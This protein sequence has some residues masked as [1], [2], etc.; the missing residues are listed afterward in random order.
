MGEGKGLKT[1]WWESGGF[2]GGGGGERERERER[3]G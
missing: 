2:R 3:E 1:E